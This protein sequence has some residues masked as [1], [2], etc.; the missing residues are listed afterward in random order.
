MVTDFAGK[1]ANPTFVRCHGAS[2]TELNT[3]SLHQKLGEVY[4]R[5]MAIP[6]P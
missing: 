3:K 1:L 4:S 6:Q 5:A 2:K